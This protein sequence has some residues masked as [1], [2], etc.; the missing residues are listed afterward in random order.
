MCKYQQ[1]N[2][3][4]GILRI[5][6]QSCEERPRSFRGHIFLNL[7]KF[8]PW[9]TT[10]IYGASRSLSNLA[11]VNYFLITLS[12]FIIVHSLAI[13]EIRSVE[14]YPIIF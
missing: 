10:T 12:S 3:L 11:S 13:F 7:Q 6:G 14:S 9:I 4:A 2:A 1:G 5:V 8:Q